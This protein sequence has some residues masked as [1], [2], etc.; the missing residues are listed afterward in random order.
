MQ[1]LWLVAAIVLVCFF[2][3]WRWAS[4]NWQLPCPSVFAGALESRFYGRLS[5]TSTTLD[6]MGLRPRSAR[7]RA[8]PPSCGCPCDHGSR[9]DQHSSLQRSPTAVS[10]EYARIL[11]TATGAI[12]A[13]DDADRPT[14]HKRDAVR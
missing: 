10:D 6:R 13:I 4:R 8:M 14:C 2:I 12:I 7:E 1:T 3:S 5:G 11:E 9:I